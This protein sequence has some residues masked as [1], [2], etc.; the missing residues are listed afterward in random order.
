MVER[1]STMR[2]EKSCGAVVFRDNKF[3]LL[4]NSK[5]K[6]WG[7]P[8]GHVENEETEEETARREIFEET[9]LSNLRFLPGFRQ[10]NHFSLY[11]GGK[12]VSKEVVFFLAESKSGNVTLSNEH[13]AYEW[14]GFEDAI[15]RVKFRALKSIL[16]NAAKTLDSKFTLTPLLEK[17]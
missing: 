3:L 4:R 17:T 14:L 1:R 8:K 11:L 12:K 6:N 9:G 10:I 16:V 7:A 15:H 2:H 5:S 13:S